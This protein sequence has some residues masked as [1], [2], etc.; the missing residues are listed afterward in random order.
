[1]A[2]TIIWSLSIAEKSNSLYQLAEIEL[3]SA[4]HCFHGTAVDS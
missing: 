2:V 1:M 3:L 4:S